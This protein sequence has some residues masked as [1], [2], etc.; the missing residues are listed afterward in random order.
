MKRIR[1]NL[2]GV[3]QVVTGA[4]KNKDGIPRCDNGHNREFYEDLGLSEDKIPQELKDREK[5]LEDENIELETEEVYSDVIVYEDQ[6]KLI[7]EDEEGYTTIFLDD[8]LMVE[9]LE[10][11]LE[12][13]SYLDYVNMSWLDKQILSF[14]SFFRRIKNKI[15]GSKEITYESI[16]NA[17]ENQPDYKQE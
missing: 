15:T 3:G 7:L 13:D 2:T 10:S 12:I 14:K 17:P 11:A 4:S 9:V 1:L 6:I 5:A 16:I 8:G